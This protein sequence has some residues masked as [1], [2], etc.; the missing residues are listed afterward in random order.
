MTSILTYTYPAV[1]WCRIAPD[2]HQA[3]PQGSPLVVGLGGLNGIGPRT[4]AAPV[5]YSR[6]TLTRGPMVRKK[7]SRLQVEQVRNRTWLLFCS[8]PLSLRGPAGARAG[9]PTLR[10]LQRCLEALQLTPLCGVAAR[11]PARLRLQ[12]AVPAGV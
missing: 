7:A 5:R 3:A 12:L 2:L 1:T 9:Y 10:A 8:V 11:A 4:V 6:R